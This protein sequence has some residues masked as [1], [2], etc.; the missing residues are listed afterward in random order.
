[1]NL[2][3]CLALF[4]LFACL[5]G[6]LAAAKDGNPDLVVDNG[7]VTLD[8][9]AEVITAAGGNVMNNY[10]PEYGPTGINFTDEYGNKYE[11]VPQGSSIDVFSESRPLLDYLSAQDLCELNEQMLSSTQRASLDH[12]MTF[13][14]LPG[15]PSRPAMLYVRSKYPLDGTV[16]RQDLIWYFDDL[17]SEVRYN[18]GRSEAIIK[19]FGPMN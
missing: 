5:V 11:A 2:K 14:L 6:G 10:S 19:H 3:K 7:N 1:M 15:N 17:M 12:V 18:Y 8:F 13:N 16:S 9:V 4:A